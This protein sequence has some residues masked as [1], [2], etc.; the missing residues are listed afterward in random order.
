MIPVLI[1]MQLFDPISLNLEAQGLILFGALKLHDQIML[2]VQNTL[3]RCN[4]NQ[5]RGTDVRI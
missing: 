1:L 4:S 3:C 5:S 2:D